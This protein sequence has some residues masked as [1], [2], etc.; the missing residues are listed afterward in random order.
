MFKYRML[1][2]PIRLPNIGTDS[3]AGLSAE[4]WTVHGTGL[5]SPRPGVGAAPPLHTSGRSA[6][7]QRVFFS[8]KNTRTRPER[9]PVEGE[10]S[11]GFLRVGR[12]PGAPLIGVESN[13]DCCERLN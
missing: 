11:K 1:L 5:D 2:A 7:V 6:I 8:A 12:S 3:L 13:R 4:A 10:S 9:D